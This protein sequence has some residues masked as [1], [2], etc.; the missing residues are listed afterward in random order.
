MVVTSWG[1][2]LRMKDLGTRP[3]CVIV[4]WYSPGV[5]EDWP[6]SKCL[7]LIEILESSG[8]MLKLMVESL[9]DCQIKMI[10][11]TMMSNKSIIKNKRTHLFRKNS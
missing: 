11:R 4:T 2:M 1:A 6:F 7:P 3:S 10:I 9:V 5:M 8:V